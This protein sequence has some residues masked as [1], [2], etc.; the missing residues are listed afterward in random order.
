MGKAKDKSKPIIRLQAELTNIMQQVSQLGNEALND[1][2]DL[3]KSRL[4]SAT[5]VQ[6][7]T[8]R[9]DWVNVNK[10]NL[11]K[12][13]FNESVNEKG[14]PVVNLLEFGSKGNPF[15]IA[16]FRACFN[17]IE[18]TIIKKLNQAK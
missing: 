4:E 10:Y 2:S 14:I 11:V 6:T 13:I 1:A 12:Y 3:V 8:T 9:A 15:A 7:G 18:D 16:T 17:E 5:P